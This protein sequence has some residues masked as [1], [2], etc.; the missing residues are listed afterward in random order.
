MG[1]LYSSA[2]T[3]PRMACMPA[4]SDGFVR[5][6]EIFVAMIELCTAEEQP[7]VDQLS[8]NLKVPQVV[9]I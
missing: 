4:W 3:A 8:I 7:R 2:D 6:G 9:G 1:M 5:G